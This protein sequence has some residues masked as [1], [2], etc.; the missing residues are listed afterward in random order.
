[1]PCRIERLSNSSRGSAVRGADACGSTGNCA[2][3]R[4]R[5]LHP[6]C[7]GSAGFAA[8]QMAEISRYALQLLNGNYTM[9]SAGCGL[10]ACCSWSLIS[11]LDR[12]AVE[13]AAEVAVRPDDPCLSSVWICRV[14]RCMRLP[15][16]TYREPINARGHAL[17]DVG[18]HAVSSSARYL[19]GSLL[20]RSFRRQ[21]RH[22]VQGKRHGAMT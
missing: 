17:R 3:M 11:R 2:V 16:Y 7:R 15:I 4:W 1:M 9:G 19:L 20:A 12:Q 13:V 6:D 21:R 22:R 18:A 10:F 8:R 5:Q 14:R